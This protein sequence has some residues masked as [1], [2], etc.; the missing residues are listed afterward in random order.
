MKGKQVHLLQ[1][2]L[3]LSLVKPPKILIA[4]SLFQELAINLF[5][6]YTKC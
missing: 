4:V 3:P 2:I 1:L 5:R 6:K